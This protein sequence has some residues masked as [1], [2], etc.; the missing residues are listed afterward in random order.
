MRDIVSRSHYD[1]ARRLLELV[2][3][4]R[5]SEDLVLLGAYKPGMNA[6]LDRAVDAQ[7]VINGYLR[8]DIDQGAGFT[9]SVEQLEALAKQKA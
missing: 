3:R 2:A 7:D 5:Q 9:S 6:D 1:A 8:Q 4:Y